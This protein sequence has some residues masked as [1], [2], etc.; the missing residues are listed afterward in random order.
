MQPEAIQPTKHSIRVGD[1]KAPVQIVEYI[2]LRCPDSRYYEMS[3][4]P[5][6]KPY[7]ERGEV[8][9]YLK[10]FDKD[11]GV[12]E[13][14][15]WAFRYVPTDEDDAYHWV[16]FFFEH[17]AE[18]GNLATE[19]GIKAYAEKQGLSPRADATSVSE[20]VLREVETV[21][22]ERI[23][24]VFVNGTAFIEKFA[25]EDFQTAVTEALR[26]RTGAND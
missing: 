23:P 1:P 21:G 22:V 13:R 24:T 19:A 26:Q 4:A 10:H 16:H 9:R 25:A 11:K 18:W 7:I 20:Q 6:L 5:Y 17:Q 12:L 14:G 2:N 3:I 15:K 8:V